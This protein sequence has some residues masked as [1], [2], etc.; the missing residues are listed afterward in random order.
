MAGLEDTQPH[1]WARENM[2]CTTTSEIR[3]LLRPTPIFEVGLEPGQHLRRDLAQL[4]ATSLGEN[5]RASERGSS[6]A[7]LWPEFEFSMVG[8]G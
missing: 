6:C 3:T 5:V 2:A 4:Q 8:A 1:S 7:L